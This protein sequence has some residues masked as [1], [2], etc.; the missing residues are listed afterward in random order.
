[1]RDQRHRDVLEDQGEHRGC[2]ERDDPGTRWRDVDEVRA[3]RGGDD[4]RGDA[5]GIGL[6]GRDGKARALGDHLLDDPL[7]HAIREAGSKEP[8][9][10]GLDRVDDVDHHVDDR[11]L[12]GPERSLRLGRGDDH[13]IGGPVGE[14][15]LGRVPVGRHRIDAEP[16]PGQVLVRGHVRRQARACGDDDDRGQRPTLAVVAR[17][18]RSP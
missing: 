12:A 1:M 2:E 15:R 8:G 14:L 5:G 4:V 17:V 3:R 9:V 7:V 18:R 11:L 10:V 13:D 16:A 6:A